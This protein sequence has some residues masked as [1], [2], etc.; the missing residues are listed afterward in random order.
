MCDN[1]VTTGTVVLIRLCKKADLLETK[2]TARKIERFVWMKLTF[3]L[4][5]DGCHRPSGLGCRS[6]VVVSE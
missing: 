5:K 1:S 6:V 3:D 2:L 4:G